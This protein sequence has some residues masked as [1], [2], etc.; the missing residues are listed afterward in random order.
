MRYAFLTAFVALSAGCV[1]VTEPVGDIDKAEPDKA[2]VGEW[3][4]NRT[5]QVFCVIDVPEVKGNPKGLMRMKWVG[6]S[7]WFYPTTIAKHT[8]ANVIQG[9]ELDFGKEARSR[10]RAS[11]RSG[12]RNR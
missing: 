8:Y 5:D 6:H 1:P 4:D 3:N 10:R 7:T 12:R 2:L 9:K 11:S